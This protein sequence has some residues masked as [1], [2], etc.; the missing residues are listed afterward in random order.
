MMEF[1]R[2]KTGSLK[3][4]AR[5][6]DA[7]AVLLSEAELATAEVPS[8]PLAGFEARLVALSTQATPDAATLGW[9]RA[10]V[11]ETDG[12]TPEGWERP[13]NEIG[14]A[15]CRERECQYVSISV[16]AGSLKKNNQ[17]LYYLTHIHSI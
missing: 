15:P 1:R 9:A 7:V 11:I 10:I 3:G 5:G 6:R 17:S 8:G 14:R 13:N 2:G 16:D 4:S 12:Q